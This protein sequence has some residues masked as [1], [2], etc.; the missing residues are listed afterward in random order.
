[1]LNGKSDVK[2]HQ[3]KHQRLDENN[4][5]YTEQAGIRNNEAQPLQNKRTRTF[6]IPKT[7]R[8]LTKSKKAAH[9]R[10]FNITGRTNTNAFKVKYL[11]ET[12]KRFLAQ[13]LYNAIERLIYEK[14]KKEY[15]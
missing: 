13:G 15:S 10:V 5:L 14:Y 2:Q 3:E 12:H 6:T 9:R 4:S 11:S 7:K 8:E 1:M